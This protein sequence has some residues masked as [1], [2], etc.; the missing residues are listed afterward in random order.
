MKSNAEWQEW[1]RW[2]P[3][4]GVASWRG[5]EKDGPNPWTDQE[6]YSLGN[7]W[8]DFIEHWERYGVELGTLVEIGCGAGRITNR[9]ATCFRRV[10]AVDV[11]DAVLDY[12]KTRISHP[13]I[14]WKVS[15]GLTIPA[16]DASIDAAFSCHVFQHFPSVTDQIACFAEINRVLKIGGSMMVH[17][18][19]H[20]FPASSRFFFRFVATAYRAYVALAELKASVRRSIAPLYMHSISHDKFALYEALR[21]IGFARIE[22]VTFPVRASGG[23]HTCVLAQRK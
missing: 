10:L 8:L 11:S 7:D 2:D 21:T 17:L 13:N 22:F 23:L 15:D 14:D 12:A 19:L 20:A 6:F 3:L 9:A 16:P 4:Y 18:P 1:G 5:R